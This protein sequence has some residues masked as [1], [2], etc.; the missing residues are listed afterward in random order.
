MIWY[1]SG[2]ISRDQKMGVPQNRNCIEVWMNW[3]RSLKN[4]AEAEVIHDSPINKGKFSLGVTLKPIS[5][6]NQKITMV[7]TGCTNTQNNPKK[8]PAKRVLKSL[9]V[10]SQINDRFTKI[11]LK[12]WMD[13]FNIFLFGPQRECKRSEYKVKISV[14]HNIKFMRSPLISKGICA[15]AI[16]RIG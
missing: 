11:L 9:L 6:T 15:V 16:F 12:N 4:R 7:T 8:D 5:K 3:S 14:Y 1:L 2:M 13:C 10:K